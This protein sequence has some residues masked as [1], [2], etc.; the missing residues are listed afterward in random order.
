MMKSIIK[1]SLLAGA[2]TVSSVVMAGNEDRI[3]SAGAAELLVNPWARS[4]AF[5]SAGIASTNGLE[6]QFMNVAGLAFT[7]RTQIKFN[8]SNW[9]GS[10]DISLNAAGIAQRV[11]NQSVVAMSVQ[12]FGFGDIQRTTADLP[13]G[14]IGEFSP[15]KNI[16]NLSYAREF[17]NSIFAGI[18]MKVV[19]E[20]ISNLKATGVAFD[21]GVRYVTG[22]QDHVKFGIT[23]KN[24]G[25]PMQFDGDGLGQEIFY[26]S[27]GG[28]ATLQQR[29]ASFEMPSLLGIG[30]SYDFIFSEDSKLTAAASFHANSYTNDQF[31]V[32]LD[33]GMSLEKAAINVR[34]GF[35]GE[36]DIFDRDLSTNSL[37]GLTAGFSVDALLGEKKTPMGFE[38][39][40]RSSNPFGLIHTFG[41]TL[42]LK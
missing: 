1:G 39:A 8:Y 22:E 10:A 13:E 42:S 27:T 26:E 35:I 16:I 18:T 5:G 32:G 37:T 41:V 3:G 4:T 29:P 19:N 34:A 17:S 14:G 25:T 24:V 30:G 12:S 15:R 7:D 20:N 11:G 33:Y 21:A 2:L 38:Y 28:N 31:N 6:A 23:L 36:K 40:V 9:L